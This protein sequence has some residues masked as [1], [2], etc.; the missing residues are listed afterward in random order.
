M[1]VKVHIILFHNVLD[2][3]DLENNEPHIILRSF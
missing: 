1:K 3:N 2:I